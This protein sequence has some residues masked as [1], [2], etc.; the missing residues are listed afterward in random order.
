[1]SVDEASY[2]FMP[3]EAVGWSD[4][5]G[6]PICADAVEFADPDRTARGEARARV[7]FTGYEMVWFNTGTLCNIACQNCYIESSPRN[8]RLAYISRREVGTF[9][10]EAASLVDRPREIGFTGGEP[11]MNPDFL[12][13]LEDA[14][15]HG[16][17]VVVLTNAMRPMQRRQSGL[18][19]LHQRFP[20]Q[21]SI[22]VSLDH[23]EAAGHEELRGARTWQP[24][25]DG[26]TWLAENGFDVS[27]ASRTVWGMT[28]REMRLGYALLF[29]TLALTID[30]DDPAR[31]V[32]F[33][34]MDEDGEVPE[35]SEAC[36]Q[37]LGK[38]PSDMMCANS[39]MVVKRKEATRP[40]VV[41]CTLL[42]YAEAFELGFTLDGAR[43]SVGLNHRHCARFCV[44]GGASCSAST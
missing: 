32:L 14:L 2:A 3:V 5:N 34:E 44:L 21:L 7:P 15:D 29:A 10:Q 39:R 4:A 1:M 38:S 36:W 9:L 31:L 23:F 30:A 17:S 43:G 37:K 11:F 12:G 6:K 18:L 19:V 28:E 40:A 20:G 8:N 33:P 16:F 41:A 25:I 26:L 22:R 42:P 35:I 24:A 13:M 27:V